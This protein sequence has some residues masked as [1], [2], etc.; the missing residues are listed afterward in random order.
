MII[1]SLFTALYTFNNWICSEPYDYRCNGW[2][3]LRVF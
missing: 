3:N 2:N 1:Y